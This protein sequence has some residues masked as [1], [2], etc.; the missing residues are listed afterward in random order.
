M[1][2]SKSTP[3]VI[4]V[5]MSRTYIFTRYVYTD[6]PHNLFGADYMDRE[7]ELSVITLINIMLLHLFF[8]THANT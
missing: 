5:H 2:E 6:I 1:S 3:P 7:Y 8:K 4:W